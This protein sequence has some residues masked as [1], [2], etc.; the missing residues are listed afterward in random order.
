MSVKPGII[1]DITCV[2][3]VGSHPFI[4][5]ES[6]VLYGK[7]RQT[8]AAGL[9][10]CVD[11]WTFHAKGDMADPPLQSICDGVVASPFTPRWAK[12]YY[13]VNK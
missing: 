1:H 11:G 7:A 2:L 10:K 6:F 9:T 3:P 4:T 13:L 8:S 12:K 5:T